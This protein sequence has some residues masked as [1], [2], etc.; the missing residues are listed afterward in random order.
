MDLQYSIVY[1]Q[2]PTNAAADALSRHPKPDS[3]FAVSTCSPAWLENLVQGYQEDV[4][5][6][7]LLEELILSD[8]PVRGFSLSNG[9][10]R[11]KGRIWIGSNSLAQQHVLQ[12]L[13]SSGVGG[14]SG[15]YA[16]YHR[17]KALFAWP[18]MKHTI[19]SFVEQCTVCQQAKVEH[20]KS[21]GLLQP[22]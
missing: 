12:A 13:H 21:P 14:H 5:A 19:K 1:K 11:Y 6:K 15:F 4:T 22:V 20:V 9:V 3:I 2:G 18:K 10:I 7:T 17:V 16:T 8:S